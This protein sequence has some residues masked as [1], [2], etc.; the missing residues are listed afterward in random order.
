MTTDTL[1][2][3]GLSCPQPVLTV[4]EQLEKGRGAFAVRV[5]AQVAVE[6]IIRFLGLKGVPFKISEAE[7]ECI[8]EVKLE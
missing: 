6:N 4:K 5:D 1:D 2:C 8:I 7:G 3:R